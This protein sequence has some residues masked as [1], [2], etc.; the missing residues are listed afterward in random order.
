MSAAT[1]KLAPPTAAEIRARMDSHG[2]AWAWWRSDPA[3]LPMPRRLLPGWT[4]DARISTGYGN[5]TV[6]WAGEFCGWCL[7]PD[8]VSAR[9]AEMEARDELLAE[10]ADLLPQT[11]TEPAEHRELPAL[12][13]VELARL[14]GIVNGAAT[15]E[16]NLRDEKACILRN[17][18]ERFREMEREIA[19]LRADL[20]KKGA[21]LDGERPQ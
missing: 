11:G 19:S 9:D 14:A 12:L 21:A 6:P 8:E 17:Y 18:E 15:V 7:T 20:A 13:A 16:K 3:R 4:N 10:I 2:A 5:G 1:Q